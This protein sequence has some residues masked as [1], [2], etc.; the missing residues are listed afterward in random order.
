MSNNVDERRR[1]DKVTVSFTPADRERVRQAAVAAQKW[2]A[3][4]CRD[5][6]LEKLAALE[7]AGRVLTTQNASGSD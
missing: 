6:V 3:A 5:A 1:S 7:E 4:F 2:D